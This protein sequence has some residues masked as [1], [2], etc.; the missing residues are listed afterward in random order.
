[1]FWG[2]IRDKNGIC[3]GGVIGIMDCCG[4]R[5]LNPI[6]HAPHCIYYKKNTQSSIGDIEALRKALNKE[7][8]FD[9]YFIC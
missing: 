6:R 8:E 5:L 3:R 4:E 7:E 2:N 1:M 9:P